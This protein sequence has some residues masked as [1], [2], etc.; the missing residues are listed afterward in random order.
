MANPTQAQL[1]KGAVNLTRW[2]SI[3]NGAID[4]TVTLDNGVIVK[5]VQGYLAEFREANY[6]SAWATGTAYAVRDVVVEASV[7]YVCV[8]AHT[9]GT[10]STDFSSGKWA[11]Y[12]LD[13]TQPLYLNNDLYVD[14]SLLVAD[15]LNNYVSINSTLFK[16]DTSNQ[17]VAFDTDTLFVDA[18]SDF[19]GVGTNTPASKLHV[20]LDTTTASVELAR[21]DKTSSSP[22]DNDEYYISYYAENNNNTQHEYARKSLKC[23]S[24]IDTSEKG[25]LLFETANGTNGNLEEVLSLNTDH[26]EFKKY[27]KESSTDNITAS[28]TQTQGQGQLNTQI[29]FVSSVG[30]DGD[31]VTLAP[32][33]IGQL[34]EIHNQDSFNYLQVFPYY[35]SDLGKGFD[36]PNYIPPGCSAVFRGISSTEYVLHSS[37]PAAIAPQIAHFSY[38]TNSNPPTGTDQQF[39]EGTKTFT[40]STDGVYKVTVLVKDQHDGGFTRSRVIVDYEGTATY[41]NNDSNSGGARKAYHQMNG[42]PSPVG[43]ATH[44]FVSLWQ[45]TVGQ[46]IV[47]IPTYRCDYSTANHSGDCAFYVEKV[48][49]NYTAIV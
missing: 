29:N 10:F 6:R 44:T 39:A 37:T 34:Q 8:I 17:T 32:A 9:S 48:S 31:V 2:D 43:Q 4:A 36:T 14:T 26:V 46:T 38:T 25:E 42:I 13:T 3:V 49:E 30:T 27:T 28:T 5:T 7:V 11:I 16:A 45:C 15:S 1:D 47:L 20:S 33:F 19:V 22:N 35:G 21:Y 41:L 24:V 18:A 12:Q 40:A 23:T